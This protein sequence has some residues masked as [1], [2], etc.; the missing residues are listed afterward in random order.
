MVSQVQGTLCQ[1]G[2]ERPEGW[3]GTLI[4]SE[5]IKNALERMGATGPK[6]EE[7]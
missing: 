3:E 4:I 7:V 6:F 5:D 2:H 1:G